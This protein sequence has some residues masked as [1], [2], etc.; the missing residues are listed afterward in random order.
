MKN[1]KSYGEGEKGQGVTIHLEPGIN[2]IAGKNGAGKS[3][4]IE[5]IGYALFDAEPLRG[6]TRIAKNTYLLRNGCKAGEVDVWFW[7][8]DCLY[9]VERDVGNGGRRWKVIRQDDDFIEA[10]G[11]KEVKDF[12]AHMAGVENPDR[13]AEV[14]HSLLGVKQG[15]FTI[16]FDLKPSEAKNHFDPLLDVDI[17][18]QC[19]EVLREPCN[20][21]RQ[22]MASLRAVISGL[23]GQI[24]QIQDAPE[25]LEEGV[26]QRTTLEILVEKC[27]EQLKQAA[28]QLEQYDALMNTYQS[29]M[30]KVSEAR[31]LVA[32]ANADVN[33]STVRVE[34]ARQAGKILQ[35]NQLDFEAYTQLEMQ[36]A[37]L[38]KQRLRRDQ[39]QKKLMDL[40]REETGMAKDLEARRLEAQRDRE[41]AVSKELDYQPRIEKLG[42][43]LEQYQG[44]EEA[45]QRSYRQAEDLRTN[46]TA[47][48]EWL[49]G[50]SAINKPAIEQ[51][52]DLEQILQQLDQH[53]AGQLVKAKEELA[54]VESQ[55]QSC[56][57]LL[58][59][60]R[61][62]KITLEQQLARLS[63]GQ[64]PLLGTSCNQFDPAKAR[65]DLALL[66]GKLQQAAVEH[67]EKLEQLSL[68]R[69]QVEKC[70]AAEKTQ[71]EKLARASQLAKG[72]TGLYGQME[73][74]KGRTA[75]ENLAQVLKLGG[76][77][78]R[79]ETLAETKD[80]SAN[81]F[82]TL[83]GRMKNFQMALYQ[84]YQLWQPAVES[85]YK[86]AQ[87]MLTQRV[88]YKKELAAEETA[89][90]VLWEE[91]KRLQQSAENAEKK[92]LHIETGLKG[93][94]HQIK[95]ME[96]QL[97]PFHGLDNKLAEATANKTC[98]LPGYTLYLQNQPVAE[99]YELY[100]NSLEECKKKRKT[101]EI[102]LLQAEQRFKEAEAAYS[103]EKHKELKA[104]YARANL[105]LGEATSKLAEAVRW[106]E[107]Q[108]KRVE[109]M[110]KLLLQ[111]D[112][113][114][115]E[116]V[117]LQAQENILEKARYILKNSQEPVARN[118]T[119]R[120]AAQA[121]TIYNTMSS[122]AAQ[123]NWRSG[124]YTLYVTTVSGEK[125]FASLSG[126]QQMKAA[127]AMQLAMVKEF[128]RAGFCA[129]DE[130]TYGL[131]A[132]S[133]SMLAEAIGKAQEECKFEQLLLVSHDQAFD[134]KVE[135]VLNLQYLP[136][137]GTKL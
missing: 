107:E 49:R 104:I 56:R 124:D 70:L 14:Y 31:N 68:A 50:M 26:K 8:E 82:Q 74:A 114:Y 130:P 47:V 133:R 116:W 13:L 91:I 3:S 89:L 78:A 29:A 101:L 134:D 33:T 10:E 129:F 55:E 69:N 57:L 61:Q 7:H 19:F 44:G 109:V 16:P 48:V 126:G 53:M 58:E 92:A 100:L 12:L 54:K 62:D 40:Q 105:D 81:Y 121:Q 102:E 41:N 35:Q 93:V 106:V 51:L 96:Q 112:Q 75:A 46:L 20:G 94:R 79:L 27:Q 17:F 15:R 71:L 39:M 118:L 65:E 131:D 43:N 111:R 117:R 45:C 80:L 66:N 110:D 24:S 122:E 76:E 67:K 90:K 84:R 103:P 59:R 88:G 72:I 52:T 2:Q 87:A 137:E 63:G 127:L 6:N 73:D 135:H 120:V 77:L 34:E 64:C 128:S 98:H 11:E 125:R 113:Q 38:E 132:E 37:E 42:W 36:I 99:K 4:L 23:E 60:T 95:D 123:F 32:Q 136:M 83:I 1:I 9:R 5:A 115:K 85:Q 22:D 86:M 97:A 108:R 30:L 18:R 25:K 21:I 119:S 28:G